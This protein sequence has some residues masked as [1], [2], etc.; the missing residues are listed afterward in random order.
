MSDTLRFIGRLISQPRT[1]GAVAPSSQG[2]A[3]AMAA[4][5][6]PGAEGPVLELG[7]GTGVVT[8]ALIARGVAPG[9][10]TAIEYNKDFAALV[11]ARYPGVRV[12]NGDAFALG[13]TL[14]AQA[15]DTFSAV[16]SSMPLINFPVAMRVALLEDALAR[17]A[18]GA[19]FVQFSYRLHC[20]VAPPAGVSV[21]RAAFVLFNLPPARVWVYRRTG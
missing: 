16:L 7:P 1:V 9:R 13:K 11:A 10:I 20:P 19:P 17:M 12:I 2:L 6:D 3:R 18:K 14:G 21:V 4:Q 5:I 15:G 8:A